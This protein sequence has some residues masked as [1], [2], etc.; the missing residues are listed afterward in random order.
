MLSSKNKVNSISHKVIYIEM[1]FNETVLSKATGFFS[2]FQGQTLFFT[3]RHNVTGRNNDTGEYLSKNAGVPNKIKFRLPIVKNNE[4][5][6]EIRI[7][8]GYDEFVLDL[9]RDE[10]FEKPIWI[11]HSNIGQYDV[12]GILF[13]AEDYGDLSSLAFDANE[14]KYQW[15]VASL[16]SVIGYPFGLSADGFPIWTS[17]YIASEPNVNYDGKPLFLIDSRTRQGQSG[18]PVISILK[19][20]Q[21]VEYEGI[22]YEAPGD[23]VYLIGI[24]SG[25]INSESDLGRV[26]KLDVIRDIISNGV[27]RLE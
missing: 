24:Y 25:R 4:S 23:I 3:N 6:P 1:M 27:M 21:E 2:Q 16:I 8:K 7:R 14:G 9:Y 12:V 18:S 22:I 19:K 13:K 15:E 10:H 11:E 26:W 20:G 5:N 17:G